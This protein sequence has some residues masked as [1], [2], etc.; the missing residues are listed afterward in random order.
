MTDNLFNTLLFFGTIVFYLGGVLVVY[1]LFGRSGLYVW[2]AISVIIANLAALKMIDMFGMQLTLGNAIYASTFLVTDLL[3]EKYDKESA[4]KAVNIGLFVT[5]IW[6]VATQLMMLFIPNNQDFIQPTFIMLFG[7]VPRI[8]L[9]SIFTYAVSQRIDVKLYHFWWNKSGNTEKYLWIRNNGST[10][11]SQFIDTAVF[12]I[13]AFLGVLPNS[14]MINLIFTTYLIKL[15]IA[16]CDTPILY[17]MR[18][19]K[20]K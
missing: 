14:V 12:T 1:K 18:K 20:I 3:S 10:M 16:L 5:I 6:V 19:V 17:A 4:I 15:I 13:I 9:A 11:I 8:S 2:T 7:M